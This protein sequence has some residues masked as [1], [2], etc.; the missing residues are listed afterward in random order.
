MRPLSETRV[1][2]TPTK[3]LKNKINLEPKFQ[4]IY[5]NLIADK[6]DILDLTGA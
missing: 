1:L 6:L 5:D 3:K 4:K 2:K